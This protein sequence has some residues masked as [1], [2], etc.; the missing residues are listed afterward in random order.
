M[1]FFPDSKSTVSSSSLFLLT[2]RVFRDYL[3]SFIWNN[4][5]FSQCGVIFLLLCCVVDKNEI[6]Y[7]QEVKPL[8]VWLETNHYTVG[9]YL[10]R[11]W[12]DGAVTCNRQMRTDG[13]LGL[14]TPLVGPK[15][16]SLSWVTFIRAMSARYTTSIFQ[17]TDFGCTWKLLR[18]YRKRK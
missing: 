4:F 7:T 15:H 16:M 8:F 9:S 1:F 5:F 12:E 11:L 14:H 2:G 6:Y 18:K 13:A 3:W 10:F 17:S